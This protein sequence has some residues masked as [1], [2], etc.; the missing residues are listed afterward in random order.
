MSFD[1]VIV[2]AGPAGSV[3]AYE[4]AK[5]GFK[6]LLL[7]KGSIPREKACGGAVMYRGIRI[8]NGEV[9]REVIERK[10][11]GIKFGFNNGNYRI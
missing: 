4:S 1:V 5:K 11:F 9:P 2:G 3:A 10:I 7:E 8:I 6:T